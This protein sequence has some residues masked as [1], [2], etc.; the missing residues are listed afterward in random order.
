MLSARTIFLNMAKKFPAW[1]DINKRP[2]TSVAGKY[3]QSIMEENDSVKIAL[4]KYKSDFFLI[5]YLGRED[6]ILSKAYIYQVG[7]YEK[8]L[9]MVTPT[10]EVTTDARAFIDDF[11]SYILYQGGFIVVSPKNAPKDG[12]C[13]YKRDGSTYGGKLIERAL[14]NIFDE[15]ALF[16]GLSRYKGESNK[17]L[18]QRCLLVF[19]NRTNSSQEGLKN[20]IVNAISTQIAIDKDDIIFEKPDE[21]NLALADEDFGTLYERLAEFNHDAFRNK[22][23]DM[24]T[25]EHN[26]KKLSYVP[27]IWDAP[28]P[29]Y[30]DGTGQNDDLKVRPVDSNSGAKTNVEVYGYKKSRVAAEE[31]VRKRSI[32][33]KIPLTLKQYKNQLNILDVNYNVIAEPAVKLRPQDITLQGRKKFTGKRTYKLSDIIQESGGARKEHMGAINA[34]GKYIVQ[35]LPKDEFSPINISKAVIADGKTE[36]NLLKAKDGFEIDSSGLHNVSAAIHVE[37]LSDASSYTSMRDTIEGLQLAPRC[38]EGELVVDISNNPGEAIYLSHKG[39]M[40]DYS[41][42]D[43]VTAIG[44]DYSDGVYTAST[45]SLAPSLDIDID[46]AN[47][48]FEFLE[49]AKGEMQGSATVTIYIND[50]VDVINSGLWGAARKYSRSFDRLTR[51]R[52]HIQKA[53]SNAISFGG[54]KAASYDIKLSF[55]HGIPISTPQAILT[56]KV[57]GKNFMH[58]KFKAY[59][60]NS[61]IIKY[62]HVGDTSKNLVY[63]IEHDFKKNTWLNITSDCRVSLYRMANNQRVLVKSGLRTGDL[64]RN[65]TSQTIRMAVDLGDIEEIETSTTPISKTT[66]KGQLTS[67][68]SLAPNESLSEI[69]VIGSGYQIARRYTLDKLLGLAMDEEVYVARSVGGF[70]IRNLTTEDE[71]LASVA[72]SQIDKE[73]VQ[74]V[75]EGLPQN[76]TGRF[77]VGESNVTEGDSSFLPFSTFYLV[78]ASDNRSTGYAQQRMVRQTA[79][80]IPLPRSFSPVLEDGRLYLYK[81]TLSGETAGKNVQV[82]FEKSVN[83]KQIFEPWSLGIKEYGIAIHV[84]ADLDNISNY[85]SEEQKINDYY[86]VSTQIALKD[87]FMWSGEEHEYACYIVEP[88]E[89]MEVDYTTEICGQDLV[90]EEDGFNKLWYAMVPSIDEIHCGDAIIPPDDYS[91]VSEGGILVWNTDKYIGKTVNVYYTYNKPIA[92]SYTSVDAL[93]DLIG[94]SIDTLALI[95][96]TPTIIEDM[97]NGEYRNVT[98]NGKV[99]DKITATCSNNDFKAT[100]SKNRITVTHLGKKT[101]NMVKTGYYYDQGKEYYFFEHQRKEIPST[102]KMF[103]TENADIM[104]G[105]FVFSQPTSNFILDSAMDGDRLDTAAFI[106]MAAHKEIDGVSK[107]GAVTACDSLHKWTRLDMDVE[108]TGTNSNRKLRFKPLSKLSYALIEITGGVKKNAI[109][110]F[111][112]EGN[113]KGTVM[114]EVLANEDSMKKSVFCNRYAKMNTEDGIAYFIFD[115]DTNESMRY[116]L[117]IE[118]DGTVDDIVLKDYDKTESVTKLHSRN[119]ETMRLEIEEEKPKHYMEAINFDINGNV[120]TDTE[121]TSD[122]TIRT[123]SNV[124]YGVTKIFDSRTNMDKLINDS[125]AFIRKDTDIYTEDVEGKVTISGISVPNNTSVK[126]VYVKINDVAIKGLNNFDVHIATSESEDRNYHEIRFSRKTNLASAHS[127]A[128]GAYMQ[129]EIK[130]P[131]RSVITNVEVYV[132]YVEASKSLSVGVNDHG[133]ILTKVYDTLFAGSYRPFKI[134]GRAEK[135]K[136]IV[137]CVRGCR[138]NSKGE[139]V[140]TKWYNYVLDENLMLTENDHIFDKYRLFQFLVSFNSAKAKLNIDDIIFEVV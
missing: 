122:G 101:A 117:M 73:C 105:E 85:A 139:A 26:F 53:G 7:S 107:L 109:L 106:D 66:Y 135:Y 30:Q 76:V 112:Y 83:G 123:G 103:E 137:F 50:T 120:M 44:F 43:A 81:I 70:I 128:M 20:A 25:W 118:N 133:H 114:K 4:D 35:F 90:A 12:K 14:W 140:W 100:V 65:T 87:T 77:I 54:F 49:P 89:G 74:F 6:S 93:Y 95:D 64:Y 121:I 108:L 21:K 36:T 88:P 63:E 116:F 15:Y 127:A 31:Y 124:D 96:K 2:T 24:D 59:D 72:K 131:A 68:I 104:D 111:A 1:M 61:P 16:L 134:V 86:I 33:Q 32:Q 91:V 62:I 94:Y 80:R 52:V 39:V 47:F 22:K 55:E 71:R 69:S 99:P 78:T 11:D 129:I 19:K 92:L 27:H 136:D 8:S 132:R 60:A 17:D 57:T 5:S 84:G 13:I 34:D 119:I 126:D 115:Q 102:Q 45:S 130:I 18:L 110:S 138:I 67:F 48:E 46:C 38:S 98:I 113:I 51:V 56:P 23:W 9:E 3:L 82:N 40:A 58:V 42:S 37:K 41:D 97:M 125:K 28:V 75:L 79:S 29:V 10:L